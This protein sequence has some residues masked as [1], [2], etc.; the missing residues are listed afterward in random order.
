MN[1]IQ[2]QITQ[3]PIEIALGID[4]DGKTTAKKLYEFLEMD[5]SHYSRWVKT[6]ITDN[7]FAI[8]NEDYE[9]LATNGENSPSMASSSKKPKTGRG[10]TEDFK[11]SANF[12]KKLSMQGKGEKGE[13][14]RDY[15]IKVEDKLKEIA[16]KGITHNVKQLT[17]T[18]REV[19][20]IAG[21]LHSWVLQSIRERIA[22]LQEVG[23]DTRGLYAESTYVTKA[24]NNAQQYICTEQGCE[25]FS[26]CLEPDA[27]K[28][29]L[30]EFQDRF[31]R[32]RDVL[33][34]K[35]VKKLPKLICLADVEEKDPL[36]RLFKTDTGGIVL[37]N[38]E[39]HNLTQDEIE[40][41]SRFVPELEKYEVGKTQYVVSA[42]LRE[43]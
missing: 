7:P 39:V 21:K 1:E 12:A 41:L 31:E 11:L 25:D 40:Q 8:E 24:N 32:M 4:A 36:I 29:F 15:F 23:F 14:A 33:D 27:R 2:N 19:S 10:N 13:Q 34:G 17:I 9:V 22:D 5:A 26:R 42:F 16:T 43:A 35:P 6:N 30:M 38:D 28:L 18:S 3:T 37:I 20:K